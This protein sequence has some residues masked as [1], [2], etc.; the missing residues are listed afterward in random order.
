[1]KHPDNK[2]F[3]SNAN[4]N[5][6]WIECAQSLLPELF[7]ANSS[8]SPQVVLSLLTT[9]HCFV[10]AY[11]ALGYHYA[12]SRSPGQWID[13]FCRLDRSYSLTE[14][15][16]A[17]YLS[18]AA[19]ALVWTEHGVPSDEPVASWCANDHR[20]ASRQRVEGLPSKVRPGKS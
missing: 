18:A 9:P 16:A 1:M 13:S 10:L 12:P 8:F 7:P 17:C 19:A 3:P 15:G 2:P 11:A 5:K 6:M 20:L 4:D 14:L